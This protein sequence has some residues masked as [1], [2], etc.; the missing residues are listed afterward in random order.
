MKIRVDCY[1]G[2]RGDETPRRLFFDERSIEVIEVIDRW[3]GSDHR[4]FKLKGSDQATYII[5]QDTL[6]H[7]W[8]MTMYQTPSLCDERGA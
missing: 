5:R 2:H 7:C 4:Y 1:A 3:I 6:M 8:E